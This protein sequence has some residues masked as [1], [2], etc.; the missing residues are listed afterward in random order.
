MREQ[1]LQILQSKDWADYDELSSI[2][3]EYFWQIFIK[4]VKA[5]IKELFKR[6]KR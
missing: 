4:N 6:S 3:E 2:L 5:V 1:I